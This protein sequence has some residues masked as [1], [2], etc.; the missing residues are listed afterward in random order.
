MEE[1]K[2]LRKR[3]RE[4]YGDLLQKSYP[5]ASER[6][7][8][9]NLERA[10]QF[11]PFAALTGHGAAIQETARWTEQERELDEEIKRRLD[12]ELQ[13]LV[14][15]LSSHPT[16]EITYFVPDEKKQ[17]GTYITK[18]DV[19]KKIDFYKREIRMADGTAIPVDHITD[20]KR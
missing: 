9:S 18:R 11:S 17:G 20:I 14:T 19:V 8:M 3:S 7:R 4:R 1:E 16:A 13:L 6:P 12:E 2:E 5:F 10:A 15:Q